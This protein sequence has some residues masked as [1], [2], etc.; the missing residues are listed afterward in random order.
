MG[1]GDYFLLQG[2]FQ[3]QGSKPR[4]LHLPHWQAVSTPLVPAVKPNYL[5]LSSQTL[6]LKT[7]TLILVTTMGKVWQSGL[8]FASYD[9]SWGGS[10]WS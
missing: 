7:A 4:L 8:I 10:T 1:V 9:V 5:L 3:T 2:N 6:W